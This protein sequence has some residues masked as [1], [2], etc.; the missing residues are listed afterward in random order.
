MIYKGGVLNQLSKEKCK[1]VIRK[2]NVI[3][4]EEVKENL[5]VIKTFSGGTK[6]KGDAMY[7]VCLFSKFNLN[8]CLVSRRLV[9]TGRTMS[10]RVLK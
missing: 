5:I 7:A 6:A 9:I 1:D 2:T 8:R 4:A 3:L 10:L